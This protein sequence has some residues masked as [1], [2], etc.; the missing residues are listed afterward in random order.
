MA[1][2]VAAGA[3][4][5]AEVLST[6]NGNDVTPDAMPVSVPDPMAAAVVD[7]LFDAAMAARLDT[8]GL[9]LPD[10]VGVLLLMEEL[11]F[12]PLVLLFEL[13]SCPPDVGKTADTPAGADV[14]VAA[15]EV[16]DV[17]AAA[18]VVT[19]VDPSRGTDADAPVEPALM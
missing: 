4:E 12:V 14:V 11:E 15:D 13:T 10:V 17:A 6:A 8:T 2:A 19:A 16:P 5:T 7:S 1:V 9:V 3:A 18:G